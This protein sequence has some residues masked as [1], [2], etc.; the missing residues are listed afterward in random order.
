MLFIDADSCDE[1]LRSRGITRS[2]RLVMHIRC[3]VQYPPSARRSS[4]SHVGL[5][6][7][8]AGISVNLLDEALDTDFRA[9][10]LEL[11]AVLCKLV[12]G[13]VSMNAKGASSRVRWNVLNL[14]DSEGASCDVLGSRTVLRATPDWRAVG[15]T[16]DR[17][18]RAVRAVEEKGLKRV[19]TS[20]M[21][22]VII[23]GDL[24]GQQRLSRAVRIWAGG[25][26][27]RMRRELS[28]YGFVVFGLEIS[29]GSRIVRSRYAI[30]RV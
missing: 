26:G 16:D 23:L 18:R 19:V 25:A 15:G 3:S 12:S 6:L 28:W 5:L 21:N 11:L 2:K 17:K 1:P 30:I 20:V 7:Q 8:R 27:P 4:T 29:G 10:E 9:V 24:G 14:M 13:P 22:L